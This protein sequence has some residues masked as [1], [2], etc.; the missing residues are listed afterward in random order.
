LGFVVVFQA[1]RVHERWLEPFILLLPLYLFARLAE[2]RSTDANI[3]RYVTMLILLAAA[4]TLARAGQIWLGGTCR[5][6]NPMDIDYRELARQLRDDLPPGSLMV[7]DDP[8]LGGNLRHRLPE[9]PCV[10]VLDPL[11]RAPAQSPPRVVIWDDESGKDVPPW[12]D[13]ISGTLPGPSWSGASP[14]R[15]VELPPVSAG[16]RSKTLRYVVLER[17]NHQATSHPF[18]PP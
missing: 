16:G 17:G 6:D 13:Q 10:C 18:S 3:R 9:M 7:A 1:T 8:G 4:L 12:L 14:V 11:Y 2:G 5:G 15:V